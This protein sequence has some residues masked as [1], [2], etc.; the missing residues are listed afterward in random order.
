MNRSA[1]NSRGALRARL[2][3]TR[4]SVFPVR[5]TGGSPISLSATASAVSSLR[6]GRPRA[7]DDWGSR[8]GTLGGALPDALAGPDAGFNDPRLWEAQ[9]PGAGGIADA[10]SLAR[11]WSATVC[12]TFGIR[13]LDAPTLGLAVKPQSEG[14]PVFPSPPPWPRWGMGLQLDSE[15]RRYLT[16]KGFGHDG[17]GG[18]VAFAEPDLGL[19]FAFVTNLM[20]GVGDTR[21]TSIIDALRAIVVPGR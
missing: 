17:A 7:G 9:I 12:E 2:A 16:P 19:G 1:G 6:S 4:G 14:E 5:R 11:I 21:A 20:E 18:Q 15:A 13:L 8:A 3:R 10:R